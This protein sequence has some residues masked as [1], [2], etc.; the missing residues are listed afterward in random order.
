MYNLNNIFN[1]LL[2][3]RKLKFIKRPFLIFLILIFFLFVVLFLIIVNKNRKSEVN[4]SINQEIYKVDDEIIKNLSFIDQIEN[5]FNQTF[6]LKKEL[7]I[8]KFF[9]ERFIE[10]QGEFILDVSVSGEKAYSVYNKLNNRKYVLVKT[11]LINVYNSGKIIQT[12]SG[13]LIKLNSLEQVKNVSISKNAKIVDYNNNIEIL[14][15]IMLID[16]EKKIINC[17]YDSKIKSINDRVNQN[18]ENI[19]VQSDFIIL[20]NNNLKVSF[21]NNVKGEI[22]NKNNRIDF[23]GE[24]VSIKRE[25]LNTYIEIESGDY[26]IFDYNKKLSFRGAGRSHKFK[27]ELPEK[28]VNK[29]QNENSLENSSIINS[30]IE[31]KTLDYIYNSATVIYESKDDRIHFYGNNG[32]F[33]YKDYGQNYILKINK[34]NLTRL[35]ENTLF[36]SDG[37][38]LEYE[39]VNRNLAIRDKKNESN[40][41]SDIK[42]TYYRFSYNNA[43]NYVIEVD[44]EKSKI[45]FS[46]INYLYNNEKNYYYL[47]FSIFFD[48]DFKL[49]NFKNL[50]EKEEIKNYIFFSSKEGDFYSDQYFS[51]REMCIVKNYLKN[52]I[53]I[54]DDFYYDFIKEEAYSNKDVLICEYKY[55]PEFYDIFKVDTDNLLNFKNLL[56]E[57]EKNEIE[58]IEKNKENLYFFTYPASNKIIYENIQ[59]ISRFEIDKDK[60]S[61]EIRKDLS[62]FFASRIIKGDKAKINNK[63]GSFQ[64]EK[65]VKVFDF[66]NLLYIYCNNL[67]YEGKEEDTYQLDEK[68]LLIKWSNENDYLQSDKIEL[69]QRGES[70]KIVNK[71]NFASIIGYPFFINI[72]DKFIV[73]SEVME[74]LWESK[75]F[76][77]KNKVSFIFEQSDIDK[78]RGVFAKG[79]FATYLYE[80]GEL[81]ISGNCEVFIDRN[82]TKA[83]YLKIYIKKRIIEAGSLKEIKFISF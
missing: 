61:K 19:F 76:L 25:N 58:L 62:I 63:I 22:S 16:L 26:L 74:V 47:N 52:Y 77:F 32:V 3:L 11:G 51:I 79:D 12:I 37:S 56:I 42:A 2:K 60:I 64:I 57:N 10:N 75:T 18:D 9:I 83:N 80:S 82:S 67:I 20:D 44:K 78:K 53:I 66:V 23:R 30:N 45:D 1:S 69:I 8:N 54:G 13:D 34:G 70:A 17:F 73:K 6:L 59:K 50:R 72:K 7:Y 5:E 4:S 49:R 65:N 15:D 33:T 35:S 36:Y 71:E 38:Y 81:N 31:I 55:E 29:E 46:K 27:I 24:F 28:D 68:V 14:S 40:K 39:F 48:K 41:K 21:K 43:F